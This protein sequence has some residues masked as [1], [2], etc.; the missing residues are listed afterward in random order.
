MFNENH[1]FA[2]NLKRN[3]VDALKKKHFPK[4]VDRYR[5]ILRQGYIFQSAV[6][7]PQDIGVAKKER[8]KAVFVLYI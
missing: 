2:A 4:G 8:E 3:V 5:Y 1:Q 6:E 7:F